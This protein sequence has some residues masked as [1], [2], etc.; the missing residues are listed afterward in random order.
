MTHGVAD[1]MLATRRA[2]DY[3]RRQPARRI[4]IPATPAADGLDSSGT[5]TPEE[6]QLAA[7]NHGMPLEAL[8]HE[9]TPV[10]LHYL[11]I[12]YDVPVVDASAWR[13]R[14]TGGVRSELSLSLGDLRSLP[15]VTMPVTFECAGNGR[16]RLQPRPISQ[17]W[18][19]E[20]VG[21]GLWGGVPL[22]PVLEE[23]GLTDGAREV[24]FT[25][26]DRGVEGGVEQCYA[27][28]LSIKDALSADALLADELDG[29]P[30]PPQHGFPLRLVVPGWY[31]M[32]NVKWLTE[33]SVRDEPFTGYQMTSAYRMYRESADDDGVA[34]TRMRPRA[35]AVPPGIPDFMTR[36]RIVPPGPCRLEGRAWSGR[37]EIVA[38]EVRVDGGPWAPAALGPPPGPHAWRPW[39]FDGWVAE[40]PGHVLSFRATDATG[41][42][43]PDEAEWNLKGY[44]NNATERMAVRVS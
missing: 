16:A 32:T 18:L 15:R 36:E 26:C 39:S 17:P 10:G 13:L 23:A 30:L 19:V 28:S 20:A 43:Q 8:R 24:V 31:G 33:I 40:P 27:R 29:Q 4:R 34:V 38:V 9:I 25:G 2:A 1:P 11:L 35:L 5:I 37:G 3:G 12:H 21:T 14:V 42:T 6:L 41:A 22:R 44:E 7:R